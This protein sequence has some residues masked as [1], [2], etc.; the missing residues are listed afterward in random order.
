MNKVKLFLVSLF[1]IL[2]VPSMSWAAYSI[3]VRDY[4]MGT[5]TVYEW[6]I[7]APASE[8][9][10]SGK[11]KISINGAVYN[12][13]FINGSSAPDDLW[14]V[15]FDSSLTGHDALNGVG[16]NVSNA[17]ATNDDLRRTPL[18]GEGGWIILNEEISLSIT[19]FNGDAGAATATIKMFVKE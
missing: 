2:I 3:S 6:S 10:D 17:N 1:L 19:N 15:D 11:G 9:S 12:V 4:R 5:W 14:D 8:D 13:Q 16:D 18:N 7:S